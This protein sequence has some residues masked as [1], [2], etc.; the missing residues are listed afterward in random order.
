MA[1]RAFFDFRATQESLD[2]RQKGGIKIECARSIETLVEQLLWLCPLDEIKTIT[3]KVICEK[4]Q[5]EA[6]D[7]D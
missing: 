5:Q 3:E 1:I 2:N 6:E 7:N 4:E